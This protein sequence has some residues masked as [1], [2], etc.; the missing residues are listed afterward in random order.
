MSRLD[1]KCPAGTNC[2]P[3]RKS[4]VLL[5]EIIL[6]RF[7]IIASSSGVSKC[8]FAKS[9]VGRTARARAIFP[10]SAKKMDGGGEELRL[11]G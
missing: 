9:P 8:F 7:L 11:T 3:Q 6:G 5:A 2:V 10:L 1:N 4:A